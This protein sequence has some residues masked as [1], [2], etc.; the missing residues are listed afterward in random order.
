[1]SDEIPR[2]LWEAM[3][4]HVDEYPLLWAARL[5][6]GVIVATGTLVDVLPII[7]REPTPHDEIPAC[8]AVDRD[9]TLR[10]WT[11]S[12][13]SGYPGY[14]GTGQH[15]AQLPYGDFTDGRYAWI[16]DDIVELDPVPATGHQGLW[17]WR[18]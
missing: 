17:E 9:G 4:A 10:L 11:R 13:L 5:P 16:L 15:H 18:H 14:V 1:M 6:R 12:D 3:R 8:F 7:G 2:P